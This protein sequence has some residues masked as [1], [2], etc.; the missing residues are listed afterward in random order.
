MQIQPKFITIL[1]KP[2][3]A[4]DL[5]S[6][7]TRNSESFSTRAFE[8]ETR[9]YE[10]IEDNNGKIWVNFWGLWKGNL[11]RNSNMTL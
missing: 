10:M 7:F 4:K 8:D 2:S 11:K 6:Y 1:E 5:K 3:W 9:E